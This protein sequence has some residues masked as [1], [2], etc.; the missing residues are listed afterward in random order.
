MSQYGPTLTKLFVLIVAVAL[1]GVTTG[2]R[3]ADSPYAR[4]TL[5]LTFGAPDDTE[6]RAST[7]VPDTELDIA[8][9]TITG[10]GPEGASFEV[11]TA[12]QNCTVGDLKQ[13]TWDIDIIG[14]NDSGVDIACGS[15]SIELDLETEPVEIALIYPEGTG[16][17]ELE[18]TLAAP[19]PAECEL[20][21]C[22]E[23]EEGAIE[24]VEPTVTDQYALVI[25]DLTTGRYLVTVY[26]SDTEG[27]IV[28]GGVEV[29][30]I[31]PD[32]TTTGSIE[33]GVNDE[34]T[35]L[36][37]IGITDDALDLADVTVEALPG[38]YFPGTDPVFTASTSG[39]TSYDLTWSLD[40]SVVSTGNTYTYTAPSI[41]RHR[42]DCVASTQ[43]RP[44]VG[45][46][47]FV[48]TVV[49]PVVVGEYDYMASFFDGDDGIDALSGARDI[50]VNHDGTMLYIAGY[51]DDAVAVFSVDQENGIPVFV[52]AISSSAEIPLDG[53]CSLSVSPDG[54]FLTAAA[55]KSGSIVL[56]GLDSSGMFSGVAAVSRLSDEFGIENDEVTDL[57]LSPSG[58]TA[59]A[60]APEANCIA[61]YDIDPEA[62]SLTP[63]EIV[64]TDTIGELS[65]IN[66][67]FIGISPDGSHIAVSAPGNDTLLILDCID[68][69][70]TPIPETAFRD[71]ENG[72]DGLNGGGGLCFGPLGKTLY[73]TGYYDNAV[74][75]FNHDETGVLW[76][77]SG[78]AENSVDGVEGMRYPR[79]VV[80]SPDG[81]SVVVAASGSDAVSVFSRDDVNGGISFDAVAENG[82]GRIVG[83]DGVRSVLFLPSGAGFYSVS[84]N[85]DA[86]AW[87]NRR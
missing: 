58:E 72:I 63:R 46:D 75:V 27:G 24:L 4:A 73:A 59:Y 64:S 79:D 34:P 74:S 28:T 23:D 32:R 81:A 39:S 84:S 29:A 12:E 69:G 20:T 16:T 56:L 18:V 25:R 5:E 61:V 26:I 36:L 76:M 1:V 33:I 65:A 62:L 86:I 22:I 15:C 57:C 41:G 9:Y 13:G 60:C 82:V 6:V 50:V 35:A 3:G 55:R 48:F 37:P 52:D 30:H 49:E 70:A 45:A 85:D 87:F 77:Y 51:G 47:G 17:L 83:L 38:P 8:L 54:T 21:V 11:Q 44:F 66:P 2:C 78:K 7:L 53:V 43:A 14:T 42:I 68:A 19:M 67:E 71:E 80:V 31:L 40:G 10:T